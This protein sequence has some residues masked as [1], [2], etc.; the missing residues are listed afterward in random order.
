MLIR[1]SH[2]MLYCAAKVASRRN[3]IRPTN[4]ASV[5]KKYMAA[6][7]V[8]IAILVEVQPVFAIQ[9]TPKF[10]NGTSMFGDV[11]AHK[12]F[13][14]LVCSEPGQ[15]VSEGITKLVASADT[16]AQK[17]HSKTAKNSPTRA[18]DSDDDSI[19][20]NIALWFAIWF[21]VYFFAIRVGLGCYEN[22][23]GADER[24]NANRALPN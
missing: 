8:I 15:N 17:L 14:R 16:D 6:F 22:N 1:V 20:H 4:P 13:S 12:G 2:Q 5:I 11:A 10:L 3:V 7:A 23:N 24:S 19:S 9:S 21:P 18:D